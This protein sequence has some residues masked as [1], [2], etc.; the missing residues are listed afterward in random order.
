VVLQPDVA[1]VFPDSVSVND[2]LRLL[3]KVANRKRF[4]A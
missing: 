2:A 1:R 4:A 3:A